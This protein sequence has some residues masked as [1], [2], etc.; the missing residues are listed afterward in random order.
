ME[1]EIKKVFVDGM[2][3]KIPEN[4]PDFVIAKLSFK[5]E[6]FISFLQSNQKTDWVNV[7]LKVSK[8]GKPY[9]EL[10]TWTPENKGEAKVE[11]KDNDDEIPF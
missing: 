11:V 2:I 9:A 4:K 5:V 6:E 1:N 10:N 8:G 3:V 7:D